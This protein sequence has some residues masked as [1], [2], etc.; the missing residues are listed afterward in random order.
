MPHPQNSLNET[1][2]FAPISDFALNVHVIMSDG[3]VN[4]MWMQLYY[5]YNFTPNN[6][7]SQIHDRSWL[8]INWCNVQ[9]L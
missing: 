7:F 6:F 3:G 4:A 9:R 8:C 1:S 2:D 5:I